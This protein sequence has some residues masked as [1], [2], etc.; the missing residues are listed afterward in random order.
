MNISDRELKIGGRVLKIARLKNEWFEDLTNENEFINILKSRSRGIDIFTFWQRLPDT[1]PVHSFYM[2][3]DDIAVLP[4]TT[5]DHWWTKQINAKTRNV[6]RKAE[7]KGVDLKIVSFDDDLVNGITDI[8]NETPY[9]QGRPFLHYGKSSVQ[10]RTEM[11]DR[12][13]ISTFI[14]AYYNKELIGFIKLLFVDRYVMMVEILSKI[15]HR[16]KSPTNALVAKTVEF[17]AERDVNN[18]IYA[19]WVEGSLGQFKIKNGFK[20]VS[21]PRYYV[22]L[23]LTGRISL[24]LNLHHGISGLLPDQTVD[25]LKSMRS[26]WYQKKT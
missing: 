23:N 5:F 20:K 18:L 24:K 3:R 19:K 17:C 21:L 26:K 2:E 13:E 11:S 25:Y 1:K 9:R 16:D 15:N 14:G 12:L 10:V 22:S 8:F 4:I 6:A 7:K